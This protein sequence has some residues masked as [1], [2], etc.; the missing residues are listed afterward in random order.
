M[1]KEHLITLDLSF[2][3]LQECVCKVRRSTR[4]RRVRLIAEPTGLVAVVPQDFSLKKLEIILKNNIGWIAGSLEKMRI[5]H[6]QAR[7]EDIFPVK[8]ELRALNEE[9]RV[10]AAE[11]SKERILARDGVIYIAPD[12]NRAEALIAMRRWVIL[13]AKET[14]PV[15]TSELA[16]EFGFSPKA[17]TVKNQRT[18]WGSCSALGNINLSAR[19]MFLPANLVQHVILHELCHLHELNHSKNFY[20][21]LSEVD[22]E[23]ERHNKEL[24]NANAFLPRWLNEG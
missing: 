19:L 7:A 3:G 11:D 18:R 15:L 2:V 23:A 4:A 6:D 9:W 5:R 24:K 10:I 1:Q 14:L 20:K 16:K 17:I 12:F 8:I 22:P 13:R 21:R